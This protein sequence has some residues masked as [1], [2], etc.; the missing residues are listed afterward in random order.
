MPLLQA[1]KLGVLTEV[2]KP[3]SIE[4]SNEKLYVVQGSTF[5]VFSLKDL[6]FIT[7]FGKKGEGP[8]ELSQMPLF[9]NSIMT[10]EDRVVA[11]GFNKIIFLSKQLKLQKELKKKDVMMFKITP[12]G[13]NFVAGRMKP[14]KDENYL[15]VVL[16]DSQLNVIKELHKQSFPERDKDIFLY[17]DSIHFDVYNNNIYIEKSSEGFIIDVFD[18][19]GN[20][21]YRIKKDFKACKVTEENR[22]AMLENFKNDKFADLMIK[23]SGGWESF[24]KTVNFIYPDTFPL[25]QD[26]IVRNDKIYVFTHETKEHKEKCIVMDLKGKMLTAKYL[27]API[28]SSFTISKLGRDTRFFGITK[29]RFYYLVENEDDE[30]WEVHVADVH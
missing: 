7:K 11:E 25:I 2:L 28:K 10:L 19:N 18:S 26:I 23:G 9:P 13:E 15:S 3:D 27:P 20:Q 17:T 5:F 16:V 14:G 22:Q 29:D 24:K 21:L 1:K 12:L 6:S 30:E 8:G 4:I